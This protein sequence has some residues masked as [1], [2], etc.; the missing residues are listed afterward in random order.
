MP[1]RIAGVLAIA[2][3]MAAACTASSTT[4]PSLIAAA[5]STPATAPVTPAP[6]TA[7]SAGPNA[8]ETPST[9]TSLLYRYSLTLPA[10]WHAGPAM[11]RWDG[12]S[13]PGNEDAAVDRFGGPSTA[14]A[15][16]FAGPTAVDLDTLVKNTITWTVRDHGDTCTERTPEVREPIEIGGEPGTFLAWNCGILINHAITV[17]DGMAFTMVMRDPGVPAA[18]DPTDRALL[19]ELVDSVVLGP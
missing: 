12:A 1:A 2:G 4:A 18:S 11:L 9:F 17:H 16:V 14:S 6:R 19:Q 7:S 5:T 8:V 15:F 10:G 3:F 13:A